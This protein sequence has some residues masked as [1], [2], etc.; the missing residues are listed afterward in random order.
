MGNQSDALSKLATICAQESTRRENS[1][2][3]SALSTSTAASDDQGVIAP[4]GDNR[5]LSHPLAAASSTCY[6]YPPPHHHHLPPPRI[7]HTPPNYPYPTVAHVYPGYHSYPPP[8]SRQPMYMRRSGGDSTEHLYSDD[9]T[10]HSGDKSED[11]KEDVEMSGSTSSEDIAAKP[12]KEGGNLKEDEKFKSSN[13]SP[14]YH[15]PYIHQGHRFRSSPPPPSPHQYP[16]PPSYGLRPIPPQRMRSYPGPPG[17]AFSHGYPPH[18]AHPHYLSRE[19]PHGPHPYYQRSHSDQNVNR[20]LPYSPDTATQRLSPS[21]TE[22]DHL[23]SEASEFDYN[24]EEANL[25]SSTWSA[26]KPMPKDDKPPIVQVKNQS[27]IRSLADVNVS[28]AKSDVAMS[29]PATEMDDDDDDSEETQLLIASPD[30]KRRASTGK[31]SSLEDAALR[32]AVTANSGKNWKKIAFHLPGRTD[33]QCLHRWQKV[34]KPGLVKGPWTPEEDALVAELVE[35]YGQMKW[36]FIARQLQGRLGKQCRERW[37]N[38]LSPD[39]K[40]GGWTKEEDKLIINA[41]ERLGNKWAEISKHLEGRT[42][43]AIKNRWNSTLKRI[44][45][46]EHGEESDNGIKG[47]HTRK[48]K[49]NTLRQQTVKRSN[50]SNDRTDSSFRI[51]QVDSTDNDA[52][53]ALSSLAYSSTHIFSQ[54]SSPL[55]S[56]MSSTKFVSPEPKNTPHLNHT[57]ESQH[58][59][60]M[61]HLHLSERQSSIL[62]ERPSL[63]EATLLMD[64]NKSF[65]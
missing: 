16:Y 26:L 39:I 49:T 34:L 12:K 9:K 27:S 5:S 2:A 46:Q 61:P 58:P 35:K 1:P 25:T 40:K 21:N 37:Y 53:A 14:V 20:R 10:C 28:P 42:D 47:K 11:D 43:N 48:R 18:A 62:S 38:H 4:P 57:E 3:T 52:A 30:Y 63:S 31:W 44:I 45:E 33:V 23:H 32:R 19:L 22:T 64:L 55:L 50:S 59:D 13:G 24:A 51:M 65:N 6:R 41:H 8:H 60:S 7:F 15:P 36:S 29:L 54:T 56:S 17:Y